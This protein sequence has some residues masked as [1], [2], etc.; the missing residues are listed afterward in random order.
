VNA[1]G[2][3]FALSLS[4]AAAPFSATLSDEADELA[5]RPASWLSLRA[6]LMKTAAD[7]SYAVMEASPYAAAQ[8]Q[9]SFSGP[10][11][12]L[13]AATLGYANPRS[14]GFSQD[15][16]TASFYGD[17]GKIVA[18]G[19]GAK[20]A[21]F[22]AVDLFGVVSGPFTSA[23]LFSGGAV[24][25]LNGHFGGAWLLKEGAHSLGAAVSVKLSG[26]H[27]NMYSNLKFE[28]VPSAA[29][30]VE[31]AARRGETRL[32]V[33]A[34]GSAARGEL[35]LRPYVGLSLSRE[36]LSTVLAAEV[37]RS[38]NPFYP[39]VVGAGAQ[40]TAAV[41]DHVS[42]GLRAQASRRRFP[43]D[44]ASSD[45]LRG[46]LTITWHE[47]PVRGRV[48][49]GAGDDGARRAFSAEEDKALADRVPPAGYAGIFRDALADA[50][51]FADFTRRIPVNG[52]DDVLAALSAWTSSFGAKNYNHDELHR[53]NVQD[54]DELYRRARDSYLKDRS[55]PILVCIGSA[56]FGAALAEALGKKAGIPIAASASIVAV[57][58]EGGLASHAVTLVKVKTPE[59]GI[60]LV[61]WGRLT[62]T[63]TFDTEEAFR[64]YQAVKGMPA[65]LHSISDPARDGR[66]VG[67]LYT[68]EG[69]V[70]LRQMTFHHELRPSAPSRLFDDAPDGQSVLLER[71]RQVLEN[72]FVPAPR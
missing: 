8:L 42:V 64:I 30:A 40:A 29:G 21:F 52:T 71:Y 14:R 25:A 38:Q 53:P 16:L 58:D 33:G 17:A 69:K 56:Q 65:L 46:E 15:W 59:Y 1:L 50:P 6:G 61:D 45:R 41:S 44:A 4:L 48:A 31:Y 22:A 28:A 18:V 13:V 12:S 3:M 24:G 27:A 26:A 43:M 10:V 20:A 57:P 62:A 23:H 60:V 37:R 70:F 11:E 51:T 36:A 19:S 47:G 54:I 67:Y 68:R 5:A 63:R 55:D 72:A 35:A 66:A 7:V 9:G 2:L 49:R 34:E 32:T 39:D